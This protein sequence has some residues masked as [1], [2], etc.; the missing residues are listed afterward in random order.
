ME[1]DPYREV[2]AKILEMVLDARGHEKEIA[3]FERRPLAVVREHTSS[4]D[5][6]I[7]LVLRMRRLAIRSH[8]AGKLD[9]ER[10]A[11]EQAHGVLAGGTGDIAFGFC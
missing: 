6:D 10:A 2:V 9:L 3:R 5:D 11:L 7:H 4:A 1:D 8:R